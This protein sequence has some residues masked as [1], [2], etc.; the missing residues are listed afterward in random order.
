MEISKRAPYIWP[1]KVNI[2]VH[3][4]GPKML[5][6]IIY[7]ATN[8]EYVL[9]FMYTSSP[10]TVELRTGQDSLVQFHSNVV[11][12]PLVVIVKYGP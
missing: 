1:F 5:I 10:G 9:Y 2:N 4:I 8:T 12:L 7:L 6:I 3:H 11:R